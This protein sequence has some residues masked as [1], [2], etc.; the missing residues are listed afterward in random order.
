MLELR[1][2]MTRVTAV[3]IFPALALVMVT[4]PVL[5]PWLFGP[6]W[7]GAVVP[8]QIL[9]VAGMAQCATAGHAQVMFAAGMPQAVMIFQ[10]ASLAALVAVVLA[11]LPLGVIGISVAVTVLNVVMLS[12]IY[13]YLL[14]KRLGEDP[15]AMARDLL[16]AVIP[17]ALLLAAIFPFFGWLRAM[18]LPAF[19]LLASVS[20]IGLAIYCIALHRLFPAASQDVRRLIRGVVPSRLK[21]RRAFP[22][23]AISTADH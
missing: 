14:Q 20:V 11:A 3:L 9:V 1:A 18:G 10:L 16:P 4:A 8:A 7:H 6:Q 12:A 2:R 21:R 19:P 17:T 15:S 13:R 22:V 5:I 23:G